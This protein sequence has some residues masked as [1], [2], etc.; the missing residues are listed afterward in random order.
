M[1]TI[2]LY[3]DT[4]YKVCVDFKNGGALIPSLPWLR[5]CRAARKLYGEPGAVWLADRAEFQLWFR[6]SAD[7]EWVLLKYQAAA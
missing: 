5:M 2:K 6:T 4:Q 3:P 7:C 1:Y